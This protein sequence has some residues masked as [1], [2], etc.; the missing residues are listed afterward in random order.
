M[1]QGT[2]RHALSDRGDDLYETPPEAVEALVRT[3]DTRPTIWEP[4]AGPGS[5]VLTLRAHGFPVIATEL[6][7][8]GERNCPDGEVGVDFFAQTERRADRIITNPPYKQADQFIRHALKLGCKTIV[9]L[10]LA[11][12]EGARRSDLIDR[13]LVAVMPF[14][15]RL[16]MM[17]RDGWQ[18]QRATSATPYAWFMF[19]PDERERPV[20]LERI[21]WRAAA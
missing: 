3:M 7:D 8:R 12:L 13:H 21:S 6:V 1:R 19:S 11:A 4:C 18:G 2:A 10:R 17:H 5:I 20:L 16:P 9:L 14:I 15:E